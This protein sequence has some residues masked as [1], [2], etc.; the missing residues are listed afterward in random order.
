MVTIHS[1]TLDVVKEEI[2]PIGEILGSSNLVHS[3]LYTSEIPDF[4]YFITKLLLLKK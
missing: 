2:P 1:F 4:I 3:V